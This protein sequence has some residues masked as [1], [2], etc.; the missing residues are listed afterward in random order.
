MA[1]ECDSKSQA[2]KYAKQALEL[3]PDNIDAQCI[4]ADFEEDEIKKLKKYNVVV[5][6]ATRV[7]K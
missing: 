1:L 5:E 7:M 2:I 6:N 3:Y 4:L